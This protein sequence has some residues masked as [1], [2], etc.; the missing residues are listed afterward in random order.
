ME[1]SE[2]AGSVAALCKKV[3]IA[4]ALADCVQA[5]RTFPGSSLATSVEMRAIQAFFS[6]ASSIALREGVIG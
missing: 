1:P 4:L 6:R 5:E 2:K 3:I